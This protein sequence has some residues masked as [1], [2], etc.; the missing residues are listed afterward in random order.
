M[1][2]GT[3][4]RDNLQERSPRVQTEEI[5]QRLEEDGIE[6]LWVTYHDYSGVAG[7]KS[8]PKEGFR[9]AL[10]NGVMFALANLNFD[11]TDRQAP[12]AVLGAESGDFL[13]KP[14]PRSYAVLPHYPGVARMHTWMLSTDGSP[15]EGCPRT[16]LD[17]AVESLRRDGYSAQ[18]ALEPEFYLLTGENPDGYR[19]INRARMFTQVG[20]RMESDLVQD[21][22]GSLRAM[23]VVV[24]QFHKEYGAGQ[25]EITAR[26]SDPVGAVDDYLSLKQVVRDAARAKGYTATFMPKV[27]ADWPGNSLR[28]HLSVWDAEGIHDLTPSEEDDASLSDVGRWFMGGILEHAAALTG[29]GSPTPNGYKRLLPGSWAAANGYWAYGNRSGVIRVPGTGRRR[30]VE[31]R[32][33]D[34]SCQPYLFLAGLLAAGL[35][36]VRKETDPGPPFEKDVGRLTPAE[37]ESAGIGFLPRSLPE[38][39]EALV[40]D[41]VVAGAVGE[42]ALRHFLLVKRHE[43]AQYDMHVHPWER[44]AYL[45]AV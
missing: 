30:H 38:A 12:D 19:A 15:W 11:V 18:V 7:A 21:V 3:P 29:L 27:Y 40:E 32:S 33:G 43:Q 28:V 31:H 14:D 8:V 1:H 44:D 23:G 26:H 10:E 25:Y 24:S 20:L 5:L 37:I 36:G 17:A 45:E 2:S 35:D 39:L 16:R 42:E 13:A 22:V 41:P 6:H 4:Q 9:S 34:N